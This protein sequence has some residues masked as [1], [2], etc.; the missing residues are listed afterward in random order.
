MYHLISFLSLLFLGASWYLSKVSINDPIRHKTY[1]IS[2]NSWLSI[3]SA[4]QKTMRDFPVASVTSHTKA[5]I[6]DGKT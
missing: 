1:N 3:K 2:C 4:D 6:S 5:I